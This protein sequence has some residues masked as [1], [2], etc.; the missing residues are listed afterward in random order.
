MSKYLSLSLMLIVMCAA[1]ASS[2]TPIVPVTPIASAGPIGTVMPIG[3]T[4][5]HTASPLPSLS[6]SSTPV[7]SPMIDLAPTAMPDVSSPTS[8]PQFT[9]SILLT[10]SQIDGSYTW[11]TGPTQVSVVAS[12]AIRVEFFTA[13]TGTGATPQLEFADANGGDGWSWYWQT[14]RGGSHLWA[15]AV[16]ANGARQSSAVLLILTNFPPPPPPTPPCPTHT[17]SAL[18]Q[19]SAQSVQLG[20][21]LVV[22]VTLLNQGCVALGRP[23]FTLRV[24]AP[25]GQPLFIPPVPDSVT[26]NLIVAPGQADSAEFVLQAAQ[27]GSGSLQANV[28]FEVHIDL[29]GP[30]Y[31]ADATSAPVNI[32]VTGNLKPPDADQPAAGICDPSA[33]EVVT[34]SI[35]TDGPSPRCVKVIGSQRLQVVNATAAAV[36]V[37]LAQFNIQLQPEQAQLFDAPSGSYLAPGV[38]RLRVIGGHAPEIWLMTP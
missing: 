31:L 33:G 19:P 23:Q 35:S 36:Q 37:Q 11:L 13:P 24:H 22:Q 28:S 8:I 12:G 2:P 7:P 26:H 5:T 29:P 17:A 9:V 14:P 38:H 27:I 3:R 6:S 30:A 18:V 20:Q 34:V 15:E 4:P 1:C 21:Q 10:P 25:Q 16:Y 32:A